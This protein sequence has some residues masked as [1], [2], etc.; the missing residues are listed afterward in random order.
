MRE[1]QR[2]KELMKY[3]EEKRRE[4]K[5]TRDRVCSVG[6]ESAISSSNQ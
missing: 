4:E 6:C 5:R 1:M 3:R 2:N